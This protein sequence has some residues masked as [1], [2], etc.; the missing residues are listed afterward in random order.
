MIRYG[1]YL[2]ISWTAICGLLCVALV[3]LWARS[4]SDGN[5]LP[6]PAGITCLSTHGTFLLMSQSIDSEYT[7]TQRPNATGEVVKPA[8][9]MPMEPKHAV[10]IQRWSST[11]WIVQLPTWLLLTLTT[12]AAIVP[13]TIRR[14]TLRTLLLMTTLV[15]VVVYFARG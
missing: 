8:Q 12:A 9:I 3:V 5:A 6:A 13:W 2:R 11:F 7:R 1:R 15:A 10:Y 14:F 4:Y